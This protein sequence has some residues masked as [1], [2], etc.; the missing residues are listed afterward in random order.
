MVETIQTYILMH[1]EIPVAKIRLD[2]ATASVSAVVELFDTAHIPV[3]IPVKKG[4]IDRAA[5][6]AWWQGRAIPA[7]RSG[8]RHALEELHISSPHA[9]LEKCLGL[10]LSD[11][12]WICP[13]DRQVSWHEV[14]FFENSFTED[15]GNILFGHPSSGG[16]VSLM[17]PDNTSDGWLKKKMDDYGWKTLSA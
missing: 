9:L 17:S 5:L 13:V 1:K 4:K 2:S 8:L 11:Q 16:E 15:V 12:Y 14:N 3:G 7:S 10:S 6:N